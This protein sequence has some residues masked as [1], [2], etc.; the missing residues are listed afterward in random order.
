[1]LSRTALVVLPMMPSCPCCSRLYFVYA[2]LSKQGTLCAGAVV[3]TLCY[4]GSRRFFCRARPTGGPTIE[5]FRWESG[6]PFRYPV[7]F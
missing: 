4:T 1:M 2:I 5:S 6:D 3:R 7:V